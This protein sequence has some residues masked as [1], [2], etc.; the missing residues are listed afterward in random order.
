[1]R[2][3]IEKL[4]KIENEYGYMA[5]L[6]HYK[7]SAGHYFKVNKDN[8]I[9][10]YHST[11]KKDDTFSFED[12]YLFFKERLF[13]EGMLSANKCI[14]AS[15]KKIHSVTP[16]AMIFKY[17]I[18]DDPKL[19]EKGLSLKDVLSKHL[20]L[21]N[22]LNTNNLD[23][24]SNVNKFATIFDYVKTNLVDI[25][26]KDDKILIFLDE[27]VDKYKKYYEK[28]LEEKIFIKNDTVIEIEGVKYGVPSFSI[29][30]N[31]KKPTLSKNPYNKYPYRISLDE[32]LLLNYLNKIKSNTVNELLL[33]TE[34]DFYG[35]D[36]LIELNA[37]T[38]SKEIVN[39]NLNYD[40]KEYES[41]LN[42]FTILQ[43]EYVNEKPIVNTSSREDLLSEID[44]MFNL[45]ENSY[46]FNRLLKIRNSDYKEFNL[47]CQT[48]AIS[49]ILISNKDNLQYYFK[50][51]GDILIDKQ[52]GD[53]LFLL[54]KELF[55][56]EIKSKK[57]RMSLDF[58]LSSLDYI[59]KDGGYDK[60]AI[61]IKDIWEKLVKAKEEKNYEIET[62]EEFFFVSGQLLYWLSTLSQSSNNTSVLLQEVLDVKNSLDIKNI[63]IENYRKYAYCI[64]VH[65]LSFINILYNAVLVYEIENEIK[66]KEFKYKYYYH[67]GLIGKN[68]KFV[69]V[70]NEQ[71]EGDNIDEE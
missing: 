61:K 49:Q 63:A 5:F 42:K 10:Y 2:D 25:C 58:M 68:I 26:K 47:K 69:S 31:D 21:I 18:F 14:D 20:E 43:S 45:E 1:M 17:G 4:K 59:N 60:M 52:F 27:E 57:L 40:N 44:W 50:E 56:R 65:S 35:I 11:G 36:V 24:D 30:L 53:I 7:P 3:I 6:E 70:K 46:L 23:I 51:N 19:K 66:I 55:K 71:L 33:D 32:A 29:T 22:H 9:L 38:K 34:N 41:N 12:D 13:F 16:Y 28:Y 54:Y 67:S 48:N 37:T 8:T 39:Y 62:N 15:N 64:P